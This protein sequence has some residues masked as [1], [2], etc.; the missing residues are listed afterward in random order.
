MFFTDRPFLKRIA[1]AADLGFSYGEMW[2]PDGT[3]NGRDCIGDPKDARQVAEAARKAGMTITNMTIGSPDGSV[4]GG[5]TNPS[6]RDQWLR[7]AREVF[8]FAKTAGIP[9][10][11]VCT[12][13]EVPG[14]SRDQMRA[15]VLEGLKRTTEIAEKEGI[16]LLL[17][18][19]NT[20]VDH[21]G[22][23]LSSVSEGA[24]LCREVAS[25]RM[26]LLF[27]IYHV[28]IMEGDLVAHIRECIDVIGHFHAAGVPGRHELQ[29]GEINHPFIASE[30]RKLGYQGIFGLEYMPTVDPGESL[31][32]ALKLLSQHY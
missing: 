20:R 12:G 29:N 2:S 8:A 30:I 22:Y 7:R 1:G 23:F 24:A 15:S 21:A 11:I 31:R 6:N 4:G 14:M 25:P 5:L 26:K 9:A 10:A 28:Q 17:E 18:P 27:D 16:T 3:Y 19:L 32:Q 13:N